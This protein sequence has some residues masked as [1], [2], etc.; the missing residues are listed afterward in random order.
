MYLERTRVGIT[1]PADVRGRDLEAATA[2]NARHLRQFERNED[3]PIAEEERRTW[4][5][6]GDRDGK[7]R[8]IKEETRRWIHPPP[9]HRHVR[10]N[11]VPYPRYEQ[12]NAIGRRNARDTRGICSVGRMMD[13]TIKFDLICAIDRP[14]RAFR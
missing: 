13:R 7:R 6:E 5:K 14:D 10:N 1:T 2:D 8:K 12:R 9:V 4:E 11:A 3:R